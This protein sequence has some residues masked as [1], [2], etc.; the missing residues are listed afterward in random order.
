MIK[1]RE[2]ETMIVSLVEDRKQLKWRLNLIKDGKITG[3]LKPV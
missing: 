1:I 2:I 3:C